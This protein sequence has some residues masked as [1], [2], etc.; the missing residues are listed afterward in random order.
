MT[1]WLAAKL[2]CHV[3]SR[4]PSAATSPS[5]SSRNGLTEISEISRLPGA[6]RTVMSRMSRRCSSDGMK[7]NTPSTL[8]KVLRSASNPARDSAAGQLPLM[9]A[10]TPRTAV[11]GMVSAMA[12]V[13]TSRI[14][15]WSTT[16][17]RVP[18]GQ[19]S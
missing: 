4:S 1:Y 3:V 15:G 8:H 19:G 18:A 11:V 6:L 10:G 12:S 7:G 9:S 13:L 2:H 5:E 17:T 14:A 16:Y